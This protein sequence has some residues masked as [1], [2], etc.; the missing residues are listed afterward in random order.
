MGGCSVWFIPVCSC[1]LRAAGDLTG[2]CTLPPA[3]TH[4]GS[5][6][7]KAVY[8]RRAVSERARAHTHAH[9]QMRAEAEQ[10]WGGRKQKFSKVDRRH[11]QTILETNEQTGKEITYALPLGVFSQRILCNV[12]NISK[13]RS[14]WLPLKH[15]PS[16]HRVFFACELV[17][18][19][20][21]GFNWRHSVT[22]KRGP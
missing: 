22:E 2:A 15:L 6:A 20:L 12:A 4:R 21:W 9:T 10:C 17:M 18:S 3:R 1:L 14:F 19:L 8:D 11:L 5:L 7:R 13:R 16:P